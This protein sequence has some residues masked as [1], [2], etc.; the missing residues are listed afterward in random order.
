M[1]MDVFDKIGYIEMRQASEKEGM[2]TC[3]KNSKE[4]K[5][6]LQ[7]QMNSI[8]FRDMMNRGMNTRKDEKRRSINPIL[9]YH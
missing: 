5:S 6:F 4:R 1:N 9:F 3:N 7:W 2:S 8:I